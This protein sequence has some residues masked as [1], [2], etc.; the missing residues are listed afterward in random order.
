MTE[1]L[2]PDRDAEQEVDFGRLGGAIVARWWL[3]VGGLVV[4]VVLG[5][6]AAAGGSTAYTARSTLYLGQPL[7]PNG[8]GLLQTLATNPTTVREVT[9]AESTIRRVGAATGMTTTQLRRGIT[10]TAVSG[11]LQK[12]GQTPLVEI[13]VRGPSP[14]KTARAADLLADISA[15]TV[16]GYVDTKI[17][18]LE[19][20][21]KQ[22][23]AELAAID[24]Q[25]ADAQKAAASGSASDRLLILTSTALTQQRRS[26]VVQ[27]I[28]SDQQLLSLAKN[29]E[30]SHLVTHAAAVKD[31]AKSARNAMVAG[32]LIGLLLGLLAALLWEPVAGRVARRP[33]V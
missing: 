26:G 13:A 3:L 20:Q 16:S 19:E 7:T 30:A 5:Y 10:V 8:G 12:A 27:D 22:S 21:L 18:T 24:A 28:V 9:H 23:Q 25:L 33:S 32:G 14:R 31:T 2:P 1:P 15:Q 17:A 4:G 6:L 11:I 29:V